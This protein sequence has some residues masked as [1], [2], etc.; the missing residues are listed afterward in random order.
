MR[1]DFLDEAPNLLEFREFCKK[2]LQN[3]DACL[4]N[5]LS[6]VLQ[7]SFFT[8]EFIRIHAFLEELPLKTDTERGEFFT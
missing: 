2:N 4:R 3:P 8:H 1:N 5:G 7:H 6:N